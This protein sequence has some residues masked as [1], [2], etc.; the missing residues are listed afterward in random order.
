[1]LHNLCLNL[2][3]SRCQQVLTWKDIVVP[4]DAAFESK[5]PA[6]LLLP[7]IHLSGHGVNRPEAVFMNTSTP[8]SRNR[9]IR[10]LS[11]NEGR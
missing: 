7:C 2:R 11:C 4:G 3:L 10:A 6:V 9:A 5:C 8:G 1:M